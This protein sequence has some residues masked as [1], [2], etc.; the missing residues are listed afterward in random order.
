METNGRKRLWIF[1]AAAYGFTALMSVLMILG[2]R[3]GLDL[4]VF[5]N[6]QMM[7]PACGVILGKL[8]AGNRKE[9][10]PMAAYI[11]FLVTAAVMICL[12]FMSVFIRIPVI[13]LGSAGKLDGW[14]LLSQ[15]TIMGGSLI[16]YI[17][18]WATNRER[19]ISAGVERKNIMASVIL[20]AVFL[21][22]FFGR[23][24]LSITIN[25]YLGNTNAGVTSLLKVLQSPKFWFYVLLLPINYVFVFIVFFGE[26]YGWRYYLQP[27]MQNKFGK[28]LG[29]FLLGLV[30]GL[31]HIN[32]DFMFYTKDSGPQA[33]VSQIIT[34][35]SIAI[36]FGYAYMKT[37]NIWV[38][39]IMHYLNNQLAALLAGGGA[40]ALQNQSIPWSHIPIHLVSSIVIF[41][42][43]LAPVYNKKKKATVEVI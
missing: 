1:I 31:W 18:F 5:I 33:F 29:V 27:V 41:L 20:I 2:Y 12:S 10:L 36:F 8:I 28:R 9:K 7:Y 34:C 30:W 43:I 32:I 14:N 37:E 42:F 26:E 11:T 4:S 23:S 39:V 13:D 21:A 6:T 16:A 17:L 22:L 38:P 15:L 3:K 25:D 40:E 35:V 24:L 19:K